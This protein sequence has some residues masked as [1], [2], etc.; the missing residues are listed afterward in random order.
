MMKKFIYIAIFLLLMSC[1]TT[2]QSAKDKYH[3]LNAPIDYRTKKDIMII[4]TGSDW[5]EFSQKARENI[6]TPEFF[7]KYSKQ[8]DIYNIDVVRNAETVDKKV[9]EENY[10]YFSDYEVT[11]LPYLALETNRGSVYA[12]DSFETDCESLESF[13]EFLQSQISER[14]AIIALEKKMNETKGFEHTIAIDNFLKTQKLKNSSRYNSLVFEA[15]ESDPENK[16]GLRKEYL[17]NTTWIEATRLMYKNDA[18]AAADAFLQIADDSLFT[19]LERQV[20]YYTAAHCLASKQENNAEV[21]AL[22]KKALELKPDSELA[23]EI[24]SA[25]QNI[26]QRIAE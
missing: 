20:I 5:D 8:F 1:Q 14:D 2:K 15:F 16:S 23:P 26:S 18:R 6:F 19:K 17:L 24:K 4:F 22:L 3:F 10:K 12:A 13:D 11:G 21:V 7:E 9:L 25:M